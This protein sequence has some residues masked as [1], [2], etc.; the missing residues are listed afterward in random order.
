MNKLSVLLI[1]LIFFNNCSFKENSRI[2]N[3]QEKLKETG[4]KKKNLY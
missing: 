2:W 1:A 3:D 4:N